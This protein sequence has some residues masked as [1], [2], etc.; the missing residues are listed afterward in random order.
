MWGRKLG[1]VTSSRAPGSRSSRLTIA[2]I[3][4]R[5][6][7]FPNRPE[8]RYQV[9]PGSCLYPSR[10]T[11]KSPT[12]MSGMTKTCASAF[13]ASAAGAVSVTGTSTKVST[14]G[15]S[16]KFPT[17]GASTTFL[18][19]TG[20]ALMVAPATLTEV[21]ER[22]FFEVLVMAFSLSRQQPDRG[23]GI[24]HARPILIRNVEYLC[25]PPPNH[26]NIIGYYL[27]SVKWIIL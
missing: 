18:R 6:V 11:T 12:P 25:R 23:G 3:A 21:F 27:N 13:G 9:L 4:C 7:S 22:A 24:V 14:T 5:T 10:D 8:R 15:V 2:A 26:K 20:V 16:T 17:T 1:Q 19:R